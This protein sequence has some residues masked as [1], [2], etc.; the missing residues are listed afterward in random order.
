MGLLYELDWGELGKEE[1][2]GEGLV[3]TRWTRVESDGMKGTICV[4]L[5]SLVI[6][7]KAASYVG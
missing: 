1:G 7:L 5:C 3:G 4:G 6:T 2:K